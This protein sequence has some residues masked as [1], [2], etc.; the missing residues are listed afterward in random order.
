MKKIFIHG[1][2]HKST[3]WDETISY[4]ENKK[5]ILCPNLSSILNGTKASYQNLYSLFTEYCNNND[6]QINLCGISLGGILALNYTLD[7]PHKVKSLVLIG[8]PHKIPKVMFSIQNIVFRFLPKSIFENMAFNK[9]DT[10]ILGNSMKDLDFSKNVK[11]IKC[12]TLVICGK[13][14]SANIKSAYYLSENIQ[15][16]K[17]KIISN[18]GH[19]VNEENP[20]ILAN[21]L[22]EYYNENK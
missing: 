17:L 10:F 9:K 2:G 7:F 16:A 22:N 5:D 12:P 14:D 13:K 19:V 11:S 8:T 4:M 15:N 21:I 1:S 20:I 18:T 6:G 3:S